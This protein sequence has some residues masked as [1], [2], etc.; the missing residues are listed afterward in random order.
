MVVLTQTSRNIKKQQNKNVK[1][2]HKTNNK[3]NTENNQTQG[4]TSAIL[5]G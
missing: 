1:T 5:F 2:Q 3:K 4:C